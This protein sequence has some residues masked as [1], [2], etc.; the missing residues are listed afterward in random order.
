[1]VKKIYYSIV[2]FTPVLLA[3]YRHR[4]QMLL[5]VSHSDENSFQ[6]AKKSYLLKAGKIK[7]SMNL[8]SNLC[9]SCAEHT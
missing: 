3:L 8:N 4:G 5:M 9:I 7:K 2:I 6:L 1:M